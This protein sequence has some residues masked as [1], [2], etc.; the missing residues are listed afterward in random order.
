[1]LNLI[2]T[3]FAKT[4]L[5]NFSYLASAIA[6]IFIILII[7]IISTPL[8]LEDLFYLVS[9]I[10]II[11]TIFTYL[12]NS[13]LERAKW[14]YSLYEKFYEKRQYKNIRNIID[15]ENEKLVEIENS[16]K[17]SLTGEKVEF[18]K[19]RDE[20]DDYLN[21]FEF[22]ASLWKMNQLTLEQVKMTFDY[23]IKLISDH[24]FLVNY[25]GD[26]RFGFENLNDLLNEY[27][28]KK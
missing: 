27:K 21:F 11:L 19:L 1:M 18:T 28:S 2:K 15:Y 9:S 4:P 25:I 22:I 26:E 10:A 3:S 12:R 23:Y 17:K 5:G 6:I 13:E 8:R 14:L 7:L 20:L 24:E 16:I